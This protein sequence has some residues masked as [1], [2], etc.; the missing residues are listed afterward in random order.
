MKLKSSFSPLS[1]N[2][3]S[4]GFTLIELVII[5][6]IVAILAAFAALS[7]DRFN[8]AITL[9]STA[10]RIA[11]DF[12]Y[13]QDLAMTSGLRTRINTTAAGYTVNFFNCPA[14]ASPAANQLGENFAMTLGT[15]YSLAP[16][17]AR[18]F[19]SKGEMV[20]DCVTPPTQAPTNFV[21]TGP[22]GTRTI[23]V[24]GSGKISVN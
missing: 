19:T 24:I 21:L 11:A 8:N 6:V 23:S 7:Y 10:D 17:A 9:N 14:T 22:S 3:F 13:A 4:K 20:S 5:I 12:K 2:I 18:Y 15:G 16:A 1:L